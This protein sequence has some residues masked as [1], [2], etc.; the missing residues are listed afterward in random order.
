ME[1]NKKY[2]L[3]DFCHLYIYGRF[4]EARKLIIEAANIVPEQLENIPQGQM[5][6][7][8]LKNYSDPSLLKMVEIEKAF[9]CAYKICYP[10]K[11]IASD[12]A[13]YGMQKM[14]SILPYARP[15]DHIYIKHLQACCY[16]YADLT[17]DE[18]DNENRYKLYREVMENNTLAESMPDKDK[19]LM[20]WAKEINDLNVSVFDKYEA[21]KSAQKRSSDY[22]KYDYKEMLKPLAEDYFSYKVNGAKNSELSYSERLKNAKDAQNAIDDIDVSASTIQSYESNP[23]KLQELR[24]SKKHKY[25]IMALGC[26]K[27]VYK[28]QN[29]QADVKAVAVQVAIEQKLFYQKYPYL[30][31]MRA[32]AAKK[33]KDI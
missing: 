7:F 27:Q 10:D 5:G 17:N 12:D 32:K 8:I 13:L 15:E 4:N 29:N 18:Q 33:A 21:V 28:D 26:L 23:K 19:F 3:Q 1:I 2:D 25:K 30:K 24:D 9:Y 20:L 22:G 16:R 11:E 6:D 31:G 14:Q